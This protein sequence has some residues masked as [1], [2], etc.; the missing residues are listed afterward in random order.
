MLKFPIGWAAPGAGARASSAARTGSA[1]RAR[2]LMVIMSLPDRRGTPARTL[3][4]GEDAPRLVP[5]E[6]VEPRVDVERRPQVGSTLG[7]VTQ[8]QLDQAGV[9]EEPGVTGAQLEGP[10]HGRVS[11]REP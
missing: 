5:E 3:Q 8:P 6:H 9:E 7:A 10:G 2:G 11:L 4:L 1:I